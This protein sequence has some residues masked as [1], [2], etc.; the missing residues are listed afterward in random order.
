ML[1][2]GSY[3]LTGTDT[4]VGKTFVAAG[5]ARA[6]QHRGINVGIMKPVET[7]CV[8][9]IAADAKLLRGAAKA[10]DPIELICPYRFRAPLAPSLAAEKEGI[11]IRNKLILKAFLE[12]KKRHEVMLVEG[13]G[14]LLVP[15][16]AKLLMRDL[17]FQMNLPIIIVTGNKLGCVN[18]TLLTI[19]AARSAGL[20]IGMVIL[21]TVDKSDI[22]FAESNGKLIRKFVRVPI[23]LVKRGAQ[24]KDFSNLL[25]D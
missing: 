18:H 25:S 20:T 10:D 9:G 3:F 24:A 16:T 14:G 22:K 12:L 19:E 6:L 5:I 21:N 4:G 11:P 13:A 7:G 23:L 8:R 15:I 17:A 2:I 1:K